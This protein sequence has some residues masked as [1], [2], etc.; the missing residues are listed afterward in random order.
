MFKKI[1][2]ISLLTIGLMADSIEMEPI[3]V[4]AYGTDDT[5]AVQ[6]TT[7][8]VEGQ[9]VIQETVPGFKQPII[10]GLMGDQVLL[11]IDGVKYTNALFRD[12]PNQYYSWIPDEFTIRAKLD[13]PM[14]S[15]SNS[16]LG[17]AIDR[18]IG[19][20]K[21]QIGIEATK[22]NHKEY[23]KYKDDV[24]Q[25]AVLN[26][27][28]GNVETPNGEVAHSGYNQKGFLLGHHDNTYGDTKMV[29]TRSDD[30][31]RTD[32]FEKGD[33]YVY[34]LQQYFLLSH[35]AWLNDTTYI[36][37]SFQQF[38]EK[39]D[40]NNLTK[41]ED[42]TDNMYGLQVGSFYDTDYGYLEYGATDNFEDIS[43]TVG[44]TDSNYNYNVFSAYTAW[45]GRIDN[46]NEYK[47]KYKY[48]VMTAKGSGLDRTLDNHSFGADYKYK[49][50]LDSYTF[51]GADLAYKFPTITNLALAR[52]DSVTE[53]ANPNLKQEQAYTLTVGQYWNGLKVSAFYKKLYDMIIRTET[54]IPDGSGGYKWQYNNT[55][56]GY[57]KGVN[58]EYN[59]K[60]E[61]GT[62]VYLFA[63]YLEGKNDYD[64]WS[65]L[66]PFQAKAKLSQD[67]KLI[68]KDMVVVKWQYAPSVPTDEMALKDQTDIRIKDHNYGYNIFDIGYEVVYHKDHKFTAYVENVFNETGRVYGSSVDFEE[69]ELKVSYN[70]YF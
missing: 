67:L 54:T 18:T 15:I 38:K 4:T 31:D 33:Y 24:W 40:R 30:V 27:K 64:Y 44:T 20:D 50:N 13:D 19:V 16:A 35:K 45:N 32:K 55:N 22:S 8:Q 17:G 39:I 11:T 37:P 43:S 29:F 58:L 62:G 3:T 59:K 6:A 12:G 25:A 21:S 56:E 52:D 47:L 57:I 61:T 9:V 49:Q 7:E 66:T 46:K 26:E 28:D 2:Y 65:K 1:L 48:S 10:N 68:D 60:Y 53:I 41:N 63:E 42:S 69:R 34:A 23:I 51:A 70:Y 14:S 36:L 5:K